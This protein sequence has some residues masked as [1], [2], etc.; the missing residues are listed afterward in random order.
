MIECS[1]WNID[2]KMIISVLGFLFG[3]F[4]FIYKNL[5]SSQLRALKNITDMLQKT[6]ET[7]IDIFLKDDVDSIDNATRQKVFMY[8]NILELNVEAFPVSI[9]SFFL[10]KK[11]NKESILWMVEDYKELILDTPIENRSMALID[12]KSEHGEARTEEVVHMS[13]NILTHLE[14]NYIV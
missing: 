2:F 6:N 11:I 14:K 12:F 3:L 7:C 13:M 1:N 5:E 9:I 10:R 8:L 4:N